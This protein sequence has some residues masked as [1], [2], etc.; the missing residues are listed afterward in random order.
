MMRFAESARKTRRS[1]F[2]MRLAM[3]TSPWRSRSLTVPRS[4]EHTSELQSRQYLLSFPTR[5]SSDLDRRVV[6]RHRQIDRLFDDA[7]VLLRRVVDLQDLFANDAVRGERPEDAAFALLDAL[8]DV[9]LALAVEELDRSHLAQVHADGVVRFIDDAAGRRDDVLLDLLA[10][11]HLLLFD[12]PVDGDDA[13]GGGL[14]RLFGVFDDVDAE[15]SEPDVDF[16]QFLRE[17]GN[18]LREYFVDLVVK[19]KSFFL[20]DRDERFDFCVLLFNRQ[21]G[22]PL[23]KIGFLFEVRSAQAGCHQLFAP[24]PGSSVAHGSTTVRTPATRPKKC[25]SAGTFT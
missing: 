8:G 22:D 21:V 12:R 25:P 1:P 17:A 19:Q 5:R 20:A 9:D 16:V 24:L 23:V 10:L 2:S 3:S 11:I 6:F 15:V 13:L 7:L 14:E 18:L 4:E